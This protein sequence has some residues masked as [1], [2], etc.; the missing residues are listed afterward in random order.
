M[1]GYKSD[2]VLTEASQITVLKDLFWKMA[3]SQ[4]LCVCENILITN[5]K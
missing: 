3:K 4:V 1:E 2:L 5:F